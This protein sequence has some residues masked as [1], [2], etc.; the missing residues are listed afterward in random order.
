M[1][2]GGWFCHTWFGGEG[3]AGAPRPASC[4]QSSEE[5]SLCLVWA[6]LFGVV[7]DIWP[8]TV[9]VRELCSSLLQCFSWCLCLT[10]LLVSQQMDLFSMAQPGLDGFGLLC[11]LCEEFLGWAECC[12]EKSP[13]AEAQRLGHTTTKQRITTNHAIFG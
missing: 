5:G 11:P 2:K 3:I 13:L 9:R 10:M 7:A 1:E 8:K 4:S 12:L 6:L